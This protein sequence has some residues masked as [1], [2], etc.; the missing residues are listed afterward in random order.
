M[1]TERKVPRKGLR[2]LLEA[3]HV[4]GDYRSTDGDELV[5]VDHK[6]FDRPDVVLEGDLKGS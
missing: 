4:G 1:K 5:G 2:A 6:R 3:C